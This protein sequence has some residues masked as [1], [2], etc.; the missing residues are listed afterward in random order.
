MEKE[1]ALKNSYFLILF[2]LIISSSGSGAMAQKIINLKQC[3]DA[4]YTVSSLSKEKEKYSQI[5]SLKQQNLAKSWLPSMDLNGSALYNSDVVDLGSALGNLPIPGIAIPPMPHDQYKITLDINQVIFD[6][7]AA[8]SA[9]AME[10]AELMVNEKQTETDLYK[11]RGQVNT[12]YFTIMLLRRQKDLLNIY[13]ELLE[14]RLNSLRSAIENGVVLKSDADVLQSELINLDQQLSENDIKTN[15]LLLVLSRITGLTIDSS[16]EFTAPAINSFDTVDLKRPEI[17]LLDMRRDQLTAGEALI[18]SRRMPK[19]FGFAT[20]GY[21]NPPGS[22][23]F[24]DTFDTYYIIGAGV[25]WNI[26]DWN[27]SK[28]ERQ[29][30][31]LQKGIIDNRKADLNDNLKRQL[32]MKQA[33]ITT[34]EKMVRSDTALVLV[35]K[36]ITASAESQHLNGTITATEYL[37]ILNNEKQAL[38]NS[39]IHLINLAL[40]RVELLNISGKEPE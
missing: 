36:R 25:K 10:Q 33:E 13:H 34:L 39:E 27:K 38:I 16:T 7:G 40:A 29:V 26:F 22:N 37:N 35:R 19:A 3:Y 9:K 17:D 23:F 24:R 2:I 32:E 14:K 1:F 30:I 28:N 6:G 15:S 20:L 8:K 11:L 12:F 5:S 31:S 18:G 21:G 4:A